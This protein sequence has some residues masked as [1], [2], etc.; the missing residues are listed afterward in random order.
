VVKSR[1][2][3][4][5]ALAHAHSVIWWLNDWINW[6]YNTTFLPPHYVTFDPY[7]KGWKFGQIPVFIWKDKFLFCKLLILFEKCMH[8]MKLMGL[9]IEWKRNANEGIVNLHFTACINYFY[10][11]WFY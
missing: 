8:G 2:E 1:R 5:V 9:G 4:L 3:E 11:C 10:F 7:K 6:T